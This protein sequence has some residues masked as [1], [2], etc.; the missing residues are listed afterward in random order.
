VSDLEGMYKSYKDI[1]EFRLVYISEAHA[2]DDRRPVP[3]AIEKGISEHKTY[4]ERCT[5]ANRLISDEKLTIPSIIDTIDNKVAEDYDAHPNR[6][7]LVRKD[8]RLGVAG[9]PGPQGWVPALKEVRVWLEDIKRLA[10]NLRFHRGAI[11]CHL[12]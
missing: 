4:S 6:I 5:V 12:F 11:L 2:T 9:G 10:W 1:V 3:Y 7:F 8:G